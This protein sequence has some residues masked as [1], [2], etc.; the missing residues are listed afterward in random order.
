MTDGA[1]FKEAF[2]VE[3]FRPLVNGGWRILAELDFERGQ[4]YIE[5]LFEAATIVVVPRKSIERSLR[6]AM[7]QSKHFRI[8]VFLTSDVQPFDTPVRVNHRRVLRYLKRRSVVV[9]PVLN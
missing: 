5:S 7:E 8:R 9:E 1:M 6:V 3:G 2:A 4:L